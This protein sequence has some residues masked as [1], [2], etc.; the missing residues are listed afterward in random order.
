MIQ[1]CSKHGVAFKQWCAECWVIVKSWA[2][3]QDDRSYFENE[4]ALDQRLDRCR[5]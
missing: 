2:E 1:R 3:Y 5:F 4:R